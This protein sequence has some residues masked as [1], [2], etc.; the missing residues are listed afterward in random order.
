MNQKRGSHPKHAAVLL[1][2]TSN[3]QNPSVILTKRAMHL[4]NHSGEVSL[5]GGKWEDQDESLMRTALRETH[6][7]IGMQPDWVDVICNLP[8]AHTWQ[9]IEVTPY[10]GVVAENLPLQPN[11]D[12]LDAIF[13]VPLSFFL[14]DQR[15]RTDV[16]PREGGAV[17][18]PAYDYQGYEIWGFT[19]RLMVEFL[20]QFWGSELSRTNPARE[21]DWSKDPIYIERRKQALAAAARVKQQ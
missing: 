8:V 10:V 16:F 21:K 20:N 14:K 17:W 12:E 9:G 13:E 18:S 6:E 11:P 15:T 7:E 1:A 3:E 2:L 5:P 4:N 19:A